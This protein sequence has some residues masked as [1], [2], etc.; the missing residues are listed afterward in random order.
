MAEAA[1]VVMA[2]PAVMTPPAMVAAAPA[3]VVMTPEARTEAVAGAEAVMTMAVPIAVL[4]IHDV[5]GA[6]VQPGVEAKRGSYRGCS[7]GQSPERQGG[8]SQA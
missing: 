3:V 2:E 8:G 5:A 1:M 7:Q 4:D 6:L